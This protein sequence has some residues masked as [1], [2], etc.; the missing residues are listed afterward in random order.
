MSENTS[1]ACTSR[2]PKKIIPC[3]RAFPVWSSR[4]GPSPQDNPGPGV[5][6]G[7]TVVCA[8]SGV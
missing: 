6:L 7:L 4:S 3:D 5:S 2:N 8:S 1:P